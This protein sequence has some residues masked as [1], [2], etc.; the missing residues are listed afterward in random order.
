MRCTCIQVYVVVKE[1]Y[2][3][4][5]KGKQCRVLTNR[6]RQLLKEKEDLRVQLSKVSSRKF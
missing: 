4:L 5:K 2:T 6:Y 1:Y 3:K